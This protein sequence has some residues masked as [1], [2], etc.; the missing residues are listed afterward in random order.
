MVEMQAFLGL[1][2][3]YRH[4]VPATA[5][6]LKPLAD[7][8]QGCLKPHARLEWTADLLAAFNVARAAIS[9]A[10][11][12]DHPSPAADLMLITDAS[13]SHVGAVLQQ[14]KGQGS[15]R[16]RGFFRKS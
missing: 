9:E 4:F 6:L 16:P 10:T 1:Y 5:Q 3:Y 2:N 12:L 11:L 14:R 15:W 13:S 7:A 8:L